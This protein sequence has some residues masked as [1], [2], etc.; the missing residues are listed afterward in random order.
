MDSKSGKSWFLGL[1]RGPAG[2]TWSSPLERMRKGW[3]AGHSGVYSS[4]AE[5]AK[6]KFWVNS[7]GGSDA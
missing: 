4:V 7:I 3:R 6:W 2:T 5:H 1:G